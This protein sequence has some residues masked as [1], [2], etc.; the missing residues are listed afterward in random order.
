MLS[1]VILIAAIVG[2]VLSVAWFLVAGRGG[3]AAPP[4]RPAYR[5]RLTDDFDL[6][7]LDW[8]WPK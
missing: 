4:G 6:N 5:S 1:T 2:I 3:G 8:R 7:D